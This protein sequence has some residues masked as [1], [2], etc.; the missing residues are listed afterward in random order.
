MVDLR[1]LMEQVFDAR[2][3]ETVIIFYDSPGKMQDNELWIRRRETA[4]E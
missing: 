2:P 3:E 1:M 4:K